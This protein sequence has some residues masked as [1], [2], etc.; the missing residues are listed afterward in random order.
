[1]VVM[2]KHPIA[3][4]SDCRAPVSEVHQVTFNELADWF[5]AATIGAKDGPAWLPVDIAQGPR[6]GERVKSISFLVLD[7]EADAEN[8][9]D[10]DG[11]VV[12]DEHGDTIKRVIGPEPPDVDAML[13]DL[14]LHHRRGILHTSYS[15]GGAI[16]PECVEHPRYRL[17]F[18][19]SRAL[20]PAELKP[21]GLH[22]AGLLGISDCIDKGALEPARLFYAPRSPTDERKQQYRHAVIEGEPLAVDDLLNEARKIEAAQKSALARRHPPA[23]ASVIDAFNAQADIGHILE[24]HGYVPKGRRRW[25]FSGSTTGLPGVRL[26]PDSGRGERVFSSHGGDP[27]NDDHA[28]DAFDCWRILRHGGDMTA[29]VRAAARLLGMNLNA[30]KPVF[31]ATS[32][33]SP[34]QQTAAIQDGQTDSHRNAPKPD[35]SMLYG[36]VG[37][38]GRAA[39][40]TTEANRYAVAAGYMAF[41]SAAA[42]RDTYVA[43]GNT[44]HH[45]RLFCLHVGR[46]GVGRKGDALTLT[47]RLREAIEN[48]YGQSDEENQRGN[49]VGVMRSAEPYCGG[50]HHGGLS[51]REGLA[52]LIHD[53]CTQGQDEIPAI[54]DKRLWVVESEFANVLHQTKREGNT[55][56]AA[57]RDAWDGISIRPATKTSKLWAS[58]PHISLSAAITPT[59]L[60]SLMQT[61]ELTNGFANRF[62]IFWAE[63]E[64]IIPFPTPTPQDVLDDLVARTMR[65]IAFARGNYPDTVNSRQITLS[66]EARLEY[67][68]C[69][70][71]EL[72]DPT[73]GDLVNGL[74]ERRAP[75]LLRMAMLFALTDL[76][77][78]IEVGHL[79]AAL[80]WTR[81][82]RDSVR[83]IFNDAAGEEAV[84]LSSD[85]AAKIAEYLRQHGQCSRS[86]LHTKCLAGHVSATRLDEALDVLLMESPPRIEVI[87][88]P[89]TGN[90][91]KPKYYRLLNGREPGE[92]ANL[93]ASTALSPL[94]TAANP[95]N[96]VHSG[97]ELHNPDSRTSHPCEFPE[98]KQQWATSPNSPSSQSSIPVAAIS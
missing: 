61:R 22:L 74:L 73:D 55:L 98:S 66:D 50:H 30:E 71:G 44:K 33:L 25:L 13:A 31:P 9:K 47:N 65:V 28:H 37:D 11:E 15:H 93:A 24:E 43:I 16:L 3:T 80:A 20:A 26:L 82:H 90:G 51:S 45:A 53:G 67:E 40:K 69:Y 39:A 4:V 7:V 83:F 81:Y 88:G 18:D 2:S 75:M 77:L 59:E 64:Q 8:V 91:R 6:T 60:R 79:R 87:E 48:R 78:Q 68:Q 95:A 17:I 97:L 49:L 14:T 5:E 86:E 85:A 94:S 35:E 72:S 46:S 38:V 27:L 96:S 57:L 56:S 1:M 42:G 29:A 76:S 10:E 36:L 41:L 23:S 19:L 21:L 58:D 84:R 70:R 63:R 92:I 54:K 52:F 62:L 89:T 34:G 32:S 12:K